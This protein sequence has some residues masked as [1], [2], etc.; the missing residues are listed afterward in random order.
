MIRERLMPASP[1]DRIGHSREQA[2]RTHAPPDAV[3]TVR[4]SLAEPNNTVRWQPNGSPRVQK[5]DAPDGRVVVRSGVVHTKSSG[6]VVD[7]CALC[8]N[9][10]LR[11]AVRNRHFTIGHCVRCGSGMVVELSDAEVPLDGMDPAH[12]HESYSQRYEDERL[13]DKAAVCWDLLVNKTNRLA[14]VQS[15]LDIG[16]G[17]GAFLNIARRAGLR[18]AGVEVSLDAAAEAAAAGHEILHG[19]IMNSRFPPDTRFDVVAMWDVLEHLE[20]PID[21]LKNAVA[22]LAPR[23][24]LFIVSPAMGS[25]FDRLGILVHRLSGGCLNQLVRMCW[26]QDHLYRFHPIGLSHVLMSLGCQN[27]RSSRVQLL[28]LRPDRYAGG[29]ILPNWTRSTRLNQWLSKSGVGLARVC[30]VRN[31]VLVCAGGMM[32]RA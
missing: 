24:R 30:R 19:S 7:G 18:T 29:A 32:E 5:H 27:V 6:D 3:D 13:R 8:G 25:V 9:V 4:R 1:A 16:C 11:I 2:D 12:H 17:K 20:R 22:M 10:N 28:S 31:K 15:I 26:S 21:A 14:N 23:G